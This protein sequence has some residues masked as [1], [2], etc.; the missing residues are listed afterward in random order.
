MAVD[1]R[2]EQL[3]RTGVDLFAR[4]SYD[5]VSIEQIAEEAGVSK[6]LLYHYFPTK[7]HFVL[8]ALERGIEEVAERTAPDPSLP[9][10][11]QITQGLDAFLDY[12]EEHAGAYSLVVRNPGGDTEIGA[13]L[14]AGRERRLAAI[15]RALRAAEGASPQVHPVAAP[16]LE[17]IVHGWFFFIEGVVLRWLD[18]GDLTRHQVRELLRLA[19]ISSLDAARSLPAD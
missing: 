13:M 7:R 15:V 16:I 11:Q 1:E 18:H 14:E 5:D 10:E 17:A 3:L 12:V 19:L 4:K 6:G 8:A 9:V 2:R